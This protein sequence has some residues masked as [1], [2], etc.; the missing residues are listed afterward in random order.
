MSQSSQTYLELSFSG[1]YRNDFQNSLLEI[2]RGPYATT[3]ILLN[4]MHVFLIGIYFNKSA[5][6][7]GSKRGTSRF[8]QCKLCLFEHSYSRP[9]TV[10]FFLPWTQAH[11]TTI[12]FFSLPDSDV[13]SI[14]ASNPVWLTIFL[15]RANAFSMGG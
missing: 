4:F 14:P 11:L 8:V 10:S 13:L 12:S 3:L 5:M 7:I 9:C 1:Y 6:A 15:H 2:L